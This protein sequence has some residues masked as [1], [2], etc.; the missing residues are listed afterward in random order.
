MLLI[1]AEALRDLVSMREAIDAVRQA[2]I[3]L[4]LGEIEQ[5]T[6]VAVGGGSG[7]AMIARHRQGGG[8]VLKA[9]TIRSDNRDRG[10]PN[11]QALVVWFDGLT[12]T[13]LAA[14]DGTALTAMRTGAA[15][16]V[17]TD[18][19]APRGA[20]VLAMIGAGAQAPDQVKA[21][22]AVRRIDEVR[23]AA[24]SRESAQSLVAR[25]APELEVR[26]IVACDTIGEALA[27]ADVVC[28]ATNS[29]TPLFQAADLSDRVHVNAIGAYTH[30]MRELPADL[31]SGADVVA[32]DQLEA[33]LAEAGDLVDAIKQ[34]ALREQD[35]VEI[36]SLL[37]RKEAPH[38]GRTVF[39]SV[40]V[41]AQDLALARLATEKASGSPDL[42]TF[43]L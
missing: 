42:P 16:G 21:V 36:G 23:V 38:A 1:S 32:I 34:G 17:A 30:S 18:L 31:L 35:M 26:R 14:I 40:G 6:R 4:S 9:I 12:G 15:S 13:P 28:T 3:D 19:L 41:A 5:P 39:K 43:E 24:R 20:A 2:F 8:T 37:S 25:L 27:G 10:L 7:L 33:T 11:I 29:G 22:C